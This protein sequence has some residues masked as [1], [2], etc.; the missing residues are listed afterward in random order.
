MVLPEW[1]KLNT[2]RL[3]KYGFQQLNRNPVAV[4][5]DP[6]SF[7]SFNPYGITATFLGSALYEPPSIAYSKP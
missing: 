1:S 5:R 3:L 4:A 6:I 2:E 7:S